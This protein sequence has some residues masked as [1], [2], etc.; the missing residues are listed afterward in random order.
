MLIN[1]QQETFFLV[2]AYDPTLKEDEFSALL[3]ESSTYVNWVFKAYKDLG[4]L[5]RVLFVRIRDLKSLVDFCKAN[6]VHHV[7]FDTES[8]NNNHVIYLKVNEDKRG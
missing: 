7:T 1:E 4:D 6:S 2:A 8:G 3:V 5:G